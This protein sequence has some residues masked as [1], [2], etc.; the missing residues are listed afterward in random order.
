M[1]QINSQSDLISMLSFAGPSYLTIRSSVCIILICDPCIRNLYNLCQSRSSYTLQKLRQCDLISRGGG[2]LNLDQT[3]MC[4][5]C[6][7][8]ITL[9]WS[10]KTQKGYPVLD[11]VSETKIMFTLYLFNQ[12]S[13]LFPFSS[14][15]FVQKSFKFSIT[16]ISL[17]YNIC[18]AF[19]D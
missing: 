14:I 3:G 5:R 2:G 6:L 15:M 11:I 1:K 8:F 16:V 19:Q 17:S 18:I 4:H 7:K 9:F 13:L 12:M 10:G